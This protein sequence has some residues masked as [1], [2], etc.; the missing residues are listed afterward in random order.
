[1]AVFSPD[2][3]FVATASSD[4]TVSIT[5]VDGLGESRVFADHNGTVNSVAFS[6]DGRLLVS[7]S[8]DGK[9][10][11]RDIGGSGEPIVLTADGSAIRHAEF[12]PDGRRV[13]TASNDGGIRIWRF[14][15]EDLLQY[16]DDS[17]RICLTIEQRMDYLNEN[18]DAAS[19]NYDDCQRREREGS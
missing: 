19:T 5:P 6:H 7:G 9:A 12:S 2:D 14:G 15:W 4:E 16:L 8:D 10:I 18:R 11:I 1:M 13:I 3:R 17:T